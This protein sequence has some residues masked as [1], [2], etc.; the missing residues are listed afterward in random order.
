MTTSTDDAVSNIASAAPTR[1]QQLA[2]LCRRA[3]LLP[4]LGR[5]RGAWRHDLRILAYHRVR[6]SI[7][8]PGF[9]FDLDLISASAEN[10]RAQMQV[11]RRHFTPLRFDEL[12]A[13]IDAGRPLPPRAVLV[14]FDDGYDDNYHIAYPIL[15]EL[16]LSAM[17]FVSTAHIDRGEPFAFDWLVH[18]VCSTN[19]TRLQIPELG[20][21]QPMPAPLAQR[22]A[23]AA[24]VLDAIKAKDAAAQR[25]LIARLEREWGQDRGAGHADCRPM[26]WDQ[27]REMRRGGMEVGSHGVAHHMLAK[28]PRAEMSSEIVQSRD[29]L[30][31]ELDA[32][33]QVLSYPVG[34]HDAFDQVVLDTV[35][36]AGYRLACTYIAG[37][38]DTAPES[39]LQLRR[40]PV[41]RDMDIAWFEAMLTLPEVF[42]YTNR[43]RKR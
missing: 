43:P 18:L 38:A 7:E 31:R 37:T 28:L 6:E 8:P 27:L 40:L 13:L 14:T 2:R 26:N 23:L 25:H 22:R 10:F 12:L 16:G 19:S 1:R 15:R 5:V 3:G 20:F 29:T 24:K 21:D 34:G 36:D 9:R 41:E 32:P 17:F 42:G 30:E 35:R 39:R 11:V 4:A 33:P